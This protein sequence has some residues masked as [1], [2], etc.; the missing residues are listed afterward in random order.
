[1]MPV[2]NTRKDLG[3]SRSVVSDEALEIIVELDQKKLR[4][5]DSHAG[6]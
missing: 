1:M 6:C 4:H 3:D 2:V 5:V